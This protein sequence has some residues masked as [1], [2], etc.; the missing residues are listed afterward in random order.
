[1]ADADQPSQFGGSG[2][3][4]GGDNAGEVD[5]NLRYNTFN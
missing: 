1:M 2:F 4:G 3:V 5:S